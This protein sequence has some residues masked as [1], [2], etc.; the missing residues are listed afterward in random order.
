[1]LVGMLLGAETAFIVDRDFIAASVY[2]GLSA[3]LSIVGIV[4]AP[5]VKW[6]ANGGMT[7]GY[8][9]AAVVCLGF[10]LMKLPKREKDDDELALDAEEGRTPPP[11]ADIMALEPSE[12][13]VKESE[14]AAPALA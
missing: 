3:A 4:N 7:L 8:L 10:V 12:S 11:A 2:L 13:E 1:V 9:F 6:N 14:P 5:T